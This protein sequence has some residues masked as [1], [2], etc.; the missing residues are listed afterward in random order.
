M[1]GADDEHADEITSVVD[2]KKNKKGSN[3]NIESLWMV[4]NCTF[5]SD[6]GMKSKSL[7]NFSFNEHCVLRKNCYFVGG[8]HYVED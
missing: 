1:S 5:S 3:K 7:K 4:E 6:R 2:T 8:R